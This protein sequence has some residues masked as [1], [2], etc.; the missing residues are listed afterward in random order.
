MIAEKNWKERLKNDKEYKVNRELARW[1]VKN[2]PS[3]VHYYLTDIGEPI[4]TYIE[5]TI[6]HRDIT[7][8]YYMFLSAP[9][10]RGEEKPLWHPVGLY[11]GNNC[12]LSSYTSR[13][14]CRYFCKV[15]NKEKQWIEIQRE[16]LDYVDY[17]SLIK[18]EVPEEESDNYQMRCVRQAYQMLSERYRQ[19]L[20]CLVIENM[21]ALE[22]YPLLE[23]YIHPRPKDGLTSDQV[24][25]NWSDKQRQ[26]AISLLK[27]YALKHLQH[28]FDSIKNK[29]E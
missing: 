29:L 2:E 4:M 19:V 9:F 18:C 5:N 24:K 28:L 6:I 25:K 1:I 13:I 12:M 23:A 10:D 20:R 17:E 3:A 27:G 15:A 21:S 7:A 8:E 22:A 26:D 16:L 14:A 11:Q